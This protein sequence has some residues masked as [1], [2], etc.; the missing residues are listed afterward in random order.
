MLCAAVL[1][2][3]G[4]EGRERLGDVLILVEVPAVVHAE[5]GEQHPVEGMR[6]PL[7]ADDVGHVHQQVEVARDG[8]ELIVDVI[9]EVEAAGLEAALVLPAHHMET[10]THLVVE[11]T[12]E[13]DGILRREEV[14]ELVV[15]ESDLA[16]TLNADEIMRGRIV[17]VRFLGI[18]RQAEA[19]RSRCQK[20][21][22]FIHK[23]PII[24]S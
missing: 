6:G 14:G 13:L 10:G 7:G 23:I 24:R 15:G 17:S 1:R 5:A 8:L 12:A 19:E 11:V 3:G 22:C 18:G 20:G 4:V 9:L 16:T 2:I 21:K